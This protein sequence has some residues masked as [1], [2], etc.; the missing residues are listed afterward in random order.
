MRD[1]EKFKVEIVENGQKKRPNLTQKKLPRYLLDE[2]IMC[3]MFLVLSI[4][5]TCNKAHKTM[6][7]KSYFPFPFKLTQIMLPVAV[8]KV[9]FFCN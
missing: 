3:V 9:L 4:S 6:I 5:R 8:K 1:Y 2:K 7:D